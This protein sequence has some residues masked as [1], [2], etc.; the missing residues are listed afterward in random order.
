MKNA[1]NL[2]S[3]NIPNQTEKLDTN[4]NEVIKK[5]EN[6]ISNAPQENN[7]IHISLPNENIC[8]N[9]FLKYLKETKKIYE[10]I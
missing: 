10:N 6:N 5:E 7:N 3:A 8:L 9:K 4:K 1:N 2:K